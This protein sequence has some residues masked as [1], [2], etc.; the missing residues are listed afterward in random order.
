MRTP[1]LLERIVTLEDER[2]LEKLVSHRGNPI[3]RQDGVRRPVPAT[4]HHHR[5][6]AKA[7]AHQQPTRRRGVSRPSRLEFVRRS[8][9]LL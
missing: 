5:V 3:L 7:F 4:Q 8:S 2:D 6:V 1:G 9:W